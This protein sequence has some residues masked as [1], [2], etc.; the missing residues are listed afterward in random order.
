MLYRVAGAAAAGVAGGLIGAAAYATTRLNGRTARTFLDAYTFTPFELGVE[1]EEVQFQSSDGLRISGWWLPRPTSDRV[2]VACAGH[3]GIKSDM[4]GIGSGLWRAGNNV[5]IFDWRS[6]GSSEGTFHTLAHHETRDL[7]GAIAYAGQRVPQAR[8]GV[9]G[10]S[11][12]AAVAILVAAR[13]PAVQAVVADSPFTS[14]A[15]L[16]R[17]GSARRRIP[18]WAVTPLADMLTAARYGYRFGDVRPIN[19]IAAI[20]PRPLLLVHGTNDSVIPVSHAHQLFEAAGEPK[21]LWLHPDLEHC[22]AYF[23]DRATYIA[24]VAQFFE[25][26]V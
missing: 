9:I 15:D 20:A 26:H 23:H 16:V 13:T 4:L 14:I 2:V 19:H 10:Y 25:Q 1:F 7:E 18:G 5:L 3:R 6:R 11:M 21:E 24:R 12:G 8:L 17:Y 22:G